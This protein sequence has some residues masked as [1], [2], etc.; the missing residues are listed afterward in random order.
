MIT[1]ANQQERP[2]RE[3]GVLALDLV[4]TRDPYAA[5]PERLARVAD[6]ERFLA[7]H[8]LDGPATA[9]DLA[10]CRALR[11][12]LRAAVAAGEAAELARRLDAIAGGLAVAPTVELDGSDGLRLGVRARDGAPVVER[13]AVA[14]VASL[15]A[16]VAEHGASRVRT[17]GGR[18]VRGRVRRH[19]AQR[20]APLLLA[21]LRQPAQR[22]A[23]PRPSARLT[24]HVHLLLQ[25]P[26]GAAVLGG[27]ALPAERVG[28][29]A[30]EA[31]ALAARP[32]RRRALDRMPSPSGRATR[33]TN[34]AR[35]GQYQLTCHVPSR[36]S[37]ARSVVPR[38]SG[39]ASRPNRTSCTARPPSAHAKCHSPS[40][41]RVPPS[42]SH[43]VLATSQAPTKRPNSMSSSASG[44]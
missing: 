18:P 5:D 35:A 41:W 13:V 15:A 21:A 36:S 33:C 44:A 29:D 16:A 38:W 28:L 26:G 9:R 11:R 37:Y 32:V 42:A 6:L 24:R 3:T 40:C 7:A 30:V 34:C 23:A 10:A 4:N 12:E 22:V 8:D 14:A 39:G 20:H 27:A 31:P 25:P 43:Q 19:L 2:F 17:C 1:Y